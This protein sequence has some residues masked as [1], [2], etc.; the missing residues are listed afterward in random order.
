MM[1][2]IRRAFYARRGHQLFE[3]DFSGVEVRV[4]AAYHEDPKF[5]DDVLHGDMHKD[6]AIELYM[7]DALDKKCPGEYNLRQGAKNGFVFPE[8]YGS[9]YANCAKGLL[10]WAKRGQLK[11]GTPAM[12][13]LS[14]KGL[15]K[16]DKNGNVRDFQKFVDHVESVEDDFWNVRYRVY[17][18]WKNRL[19]LKYQKTG[20]IDM[21][22]GFRC[23]GVMSQNDVT[24]YPVQG[25]AFHCLLWSFI[26]IDRIQREENW[27][28]RLC[29]QIHDSM[30]MDVL[31]A[32]LKKVVQTTLRVTTKDLMKHFKWINIPLEIEAD[33]CEV[34]QP[35]SEKKE[36]KLPEAA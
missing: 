32:E 8:F 36:Y 19:W 10:E 2:I 25:S 15:L 23:S 26:Q 34:D 35:W 29:G 30:V 6:M 12:V 17:N 11:D 5:I 22:T 18:R 7:L 28:S 24:N 1:R 27:D 21:F 31:P 4:S 33:L 14:N 13:H 16:L 3:P 9:Y 20:H